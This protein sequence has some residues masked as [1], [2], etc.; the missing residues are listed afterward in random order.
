MKRI[1][2]LA[3]LALAPGK[4]GEPTVSHRRVLTSL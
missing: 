1:A 3:V 4:L 2:I